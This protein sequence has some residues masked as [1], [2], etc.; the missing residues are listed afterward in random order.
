MLSKENSSGLLKEL[1][2]DIFYAYA[3]LVFVKNKLVGFLLLAAT[4]F[5][6]NI[7]LQGLIALAVATIFARFIGIK[8]DDPVN[9]LFSYNVLITGFA[10]GFLFKVT[11]L[12]VLLTRY[13]CG[14]AS[15]RGS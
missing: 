11:G 4:F 15:D 12:S 8:K 3:N 6:I 7:A 1:S 2:D 9:K 14:L 13:L 5:N 10:V